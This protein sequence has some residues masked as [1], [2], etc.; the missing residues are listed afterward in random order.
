MRI[1]WVNHASFIVESGHVRLI[2]D[3]WLEGSAFNDGWNLV[4]PT[5]L[6]YEEFSGITY[7]W[8]SHE[9]P[10]HFSPSNLRKIPELCRR[11]I[12]VLFHQTKDKQVINLCKALGFPTEELPDNRLLPIAEDFKVLSARQGLVDS[13]LA[14]FAEGKTLLNMNDCIFDTQGELEQIQK[15]I[16]KTDVLFSQFSYA[17]WVGNP[18]DHAAHRKE[19]NR[20]R[21]EMEKQIRL[22]APSV[23]VPFASFVYFSHAENF[24]MNEHVNRIADVYDFVTRDLKVSANVMY[25]GDQWEVG[26]PWDS[27]PSIARYQADFERAEALPPQTS[28]PVPFVDLQEAARTFIGK[29]ALKNNRMLLN[30]LPPA[31]IRI[32]DL[33]LNAELSFRRGLVES[34]GKRADIVLSSNSLF[35]CFKTD[36]GGE[37]LQ[38]NGRFQVPPG[39]GPRRFF[40]IF[41]VPRHNGYGSSL[42]FR[43]LG[44]QML[45]RVRAAVQS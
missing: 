25:P 15:Q 5:K 21:Q 28:P 1:V 35:Y 24:F 17:N 29:C 39:G 2:C 36:W 27:A 40:W 13:C 26:A 32:S 16:G 41:R 7:I 18:D 9:H 12:K 45:Q 34:K 14:I 37:T 11:K 10:D 6:R 19:A 31:R 22:F 20:K 8:F 30:A 4:S 38:I 42:N 43:F 44:H 23:F 3:P 33:E